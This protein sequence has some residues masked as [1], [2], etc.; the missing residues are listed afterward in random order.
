MKTN[1]G[2]KECGTPTGQLSM[3]LNV[4]LE[5]SPKTGYRFVRILF[6]TDR[7]SATKF[8][9]KVPQDRYNE[10]RYALANVVLEFEEGLST[11]E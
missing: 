11:F 7:M 1:D 2:Q 3:D 6:D 8:E 5:E 4:P 9:F 10:F